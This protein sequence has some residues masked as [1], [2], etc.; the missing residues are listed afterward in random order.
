M[1]DSQT[2]DR[3]PDIDPRLRLSAE[4]VLEVYRA[5]SVAETDDP[6]LPDSFRSEADLGEDRL[7]RDDIEYTAVST[8]ESFEQV[9]DLIRNVAKNNGLPP[10]SP[11][12]IIGN[13]VATVILTTDQDVL[14]LRDP[15]P[16]GHVSIWGDP[17]R[18]A[19][20]VKEIRSAWD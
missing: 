11:D 5:V 13:Y 12:L 10:Y 2:P 16:Q 14:Y 8:R 6:A 7:G 17:T 15:P 18:L 1:A 20:A 3:E 19:T 4:E 9:R